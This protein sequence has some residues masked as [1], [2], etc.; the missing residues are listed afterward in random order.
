MHPGCWNGILFNISW[1]LREG[2]QVETFWNIQR[3][4]TGVLKIS[5]NVEWNVELNQKT[6]YAFWLYL[7]FRSAISQRLSWNFQGVFGRILGR[8]QYF[9]GDVGGGGAKKLKY[10]TTNVYIHFSYV[11]YEQDKH[12]G[13][14]GGI[15]TP[16]PTTPV[17]GLD[18]WWFTLYLSFILFSLIF[19]SH[20]DYYRSYFLF[21]VTVLKIASTLIKEHIVFNK[22]QMVQ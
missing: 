22:T 18:A 2:H 11:F 20:L 19:T 7:I 16:Q 10:T 13:G 9:F 12:F 8:T 6:L 21:V 5:G 17:Y 4:L 15:Q 3:L 14:G 1:A